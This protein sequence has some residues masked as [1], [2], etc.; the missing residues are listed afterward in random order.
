[1]IQ[2]VIQKEMNSCFLLKLQ[3]L[4]RLYTILILQLELTQ[5]SVNYEYLK[6]SLKKTN[7][8]DTYW[9]FTYNNSW[10]EIKISMVSKYLGG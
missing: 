10:L 7:K 8:L 4:K 9:R 1:M 3:C 6:I 2:T 5:F